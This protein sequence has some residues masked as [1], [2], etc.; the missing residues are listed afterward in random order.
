[1]SGMGRQRHLRTLR[2]QRLLLGGEAD[3]HASATFLVII[4]DYSASSPDI[5]FIRLTPHNL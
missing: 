2:S 4:D 5:G 1:M 3:A